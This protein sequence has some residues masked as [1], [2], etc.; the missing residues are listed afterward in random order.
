MFGQGLDGAFGDTK[1]VKRRDLE[2][3]P[4]E[5]DGITDTRRPSRPVNDTGAISRPRQAG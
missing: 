4:A 5:G 3:V 1:S 2:P